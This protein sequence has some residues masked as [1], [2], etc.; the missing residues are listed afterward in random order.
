[1]CVTFFGRE[2]IRRTKRRVDEDNGGE[3]GWA[4]QRR[5]YSKTMYM[6]LLGLKTKKTPR[7]EIRT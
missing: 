7:R 3:E 2:A 6:S 5:K 4:C 1:M